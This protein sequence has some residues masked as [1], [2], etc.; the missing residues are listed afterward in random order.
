[1]IPIRERLIP[2][3][4][5]RSIQLT[6]CFS[7]QTQNATANLTWNLTDAQRDVVIIGTDRVTK[8]T[9]SAANIIIPQPK[10]RQSGMRSNSTELQIC[11]DDLAGITE[12]DLDKDLLVG[13][14]VVEIEVDGLRPWIEHRRFRWY[15]SDVRH[16]KGVAIL[17]LVGQTARLQKTVG[18]SISTRCQNAFLNFN[19]N[20]GSSLSGVL[21]GG[22][23]KFGFRAYKTHT[24]PTY[25]GKR[26]VRI[27][28]DADS[29][30]VDAR[31][32]ADW[33]AHGTVK[34]V[35]GPAANQIAYV[36]SNTQ[37]FLSGGIYYTDLILTT[38]LAY[39]PTGN[40]DLELRVGCPRIHSVCKAK[41]NNLD[42]FRGDRDVA[43]SDNLQRTPSAE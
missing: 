21:E 41:F 36:E 1:M 33:W 22:T 6:R 25:L 19:C 9:Y 14:R 24:D 28:E 18:E 3:R 37:P 16:G 32:A 34:F 10:R 30:P 8:I 2:L 40:N 20:A 7:I 11:I 4:A 12:E 42:N 31:A 29:F 35:S 23:Q 38:P 17:S 27:K 43:G 39:A 13:A 5:S 26:R 15:V